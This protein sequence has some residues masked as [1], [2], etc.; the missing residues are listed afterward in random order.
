M[1]SSASLREY[2]TKILERVGKGEINAA[3]ANA[4]SSLA[5]KVLATVKLEMDYAKAKGETPSVKFV[6]KNILEH[7]GI[8]H[9]IETGEVVEDE[10]DDDDDNEDEVPVKKKK[11]QK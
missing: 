5:G 10:E 1:Q 6:S 8:G 3:A 4:A 2:L 9:D 11:K 7:K